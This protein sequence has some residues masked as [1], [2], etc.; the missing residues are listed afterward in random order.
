MKRLLV[1]TVLAVLLMST[2]GATA[3]MASQ[4]RPYTADIYVITSD[5]H[6]RESPDGRLQPYTVHDHHV[7]GIDFTCTAQSDGATL[8]ASLKPVG[9]QSGVQS[10]TAWAFLGSTF[11]AD[12]VLGRDVTTR[13]INVIVTLRYSASGAVGDP[14]PDAAQFKLD[15]KDGR[16]AL[17]PLVVHTADASRHTFDEQNKPVTYTI[18]T[19][20]DGARL[21]YGDLVSPSTHEAALYVY[22]STYAKGDATA[23]GKVIVDNLQVRW[24]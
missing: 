14:A 11:F 1:L 21:T 24:A 12:D 7:M 13:P 6:W 4:L 15:I 2:A 17:H 10:G 16:G 8:R 19:D 5:N 23:S 3:A 20:A 9:T 22:L 18:T